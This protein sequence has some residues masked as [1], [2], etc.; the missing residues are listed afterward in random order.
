MP[1]CGAVSLL[2]LFRAGEFLKNSGL[3]ARIVQNRMTRKRWDERITWMQK[4]QGLG[5]WTLAIRN[6][7]PDY[8]E[9]VQGLV[10]PAEESQ[11]RT[12]RMYE[13]DYPPNPL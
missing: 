7:I 13:F 10:L 11:P 3:A 5:E 4:K 9:A 2:K 6:R 1:R 8:R 12:R